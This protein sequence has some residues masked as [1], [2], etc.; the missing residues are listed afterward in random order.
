[1]KELD[2][3][4]TEPLQY[5]NKGQAEYTNKLLMNAPTAA[6]TKFTS[7]IKQMFFEAIRE[8][9]K[10]IKNSDEFKADPGSDNE[11]TGV[12]TEFLLSM[13]KD[14]EK[15]NQLFKDLCC[16]GVVKMPNGEK[17]ALFVLDQLPL[18]DFEKLQGEYISNF[19]IGS[20]MK[21]MNEKSSG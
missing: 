15:L 5:H 21:R 11:L 10:T 3:M 6:M 8:N 2:F 7:P 20:L 16:A 9:S 4:L 1:M 17:I 14:I 19:I 18:E 13:V 12:M